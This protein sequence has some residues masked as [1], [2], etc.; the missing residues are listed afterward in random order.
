[1]GFLRENR[2]VVRVPLDEGLAFFHLAAVAHGNHRAN[3]DVVIFQ[4]AA[5]IAENGNRPV[6]V[7]HDIIAILQLHQAQIIVTDGAVKLGLNLRLLDPRSGCAADVERPH[8]ELSARLADGLSGNDPYGFTKLDL[9]A[10]RQ[11]APIA[12]DAY[13]L[14]AFAREHRA[15]L[16]L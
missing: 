7:E 11:I 12:F 3:H 2:H 1:A 5:V 15:N 9:A 14:L 8:G 10:G 6:L 13:A 16:H 4:L